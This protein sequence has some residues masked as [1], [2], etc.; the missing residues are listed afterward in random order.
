MLSSSSKN[1]KMLWSELEPLVDS[2]H[3]LG[4]DLGTTNSVIAEI[5]M[6]PGEKSPSVRCLEVKQDTPQG[7]IF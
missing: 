3:V 1:E 7:P 4:I 6:Q 5:V 2:L